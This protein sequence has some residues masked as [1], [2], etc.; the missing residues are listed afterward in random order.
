MI[1]R[2]DL[3]HRLV[4]G[5]LF[6][7]VRDQS[8]QTRYEENRVAELIREA[9]V[10]ADCRDRTVDVDRQMPADLALSLEQRALDR[11]NH[12][13]VLTLEFEFERHL[14]ESRRAR[15]PRVE[16]MPEPRRRL[17]VAH[18]IFRQRLGGLLQ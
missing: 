5:A 9:E 8:G 16:P 4:A 17:A 6:V 7:R 3:P 11:P 15:I 14:K 12:A 18:R 2:I 1:L 10:G 13:N